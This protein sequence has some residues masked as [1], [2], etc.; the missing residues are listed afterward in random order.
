MILLSRSPLSC[1][2]A[3]H[4]TLQLICCRLEAA[5]AGT[6]S[7]CM[8]CS[9]FSPWEEKH[10]LPSAAAA[11]KVRSN[12]ERL[13]KGSPRI[14]ERIVDGGWTESMRSH[15]FPTCSHSEHVWSLD[16]QTQDLDKL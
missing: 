7:P 14:A 11:S 5:A 3:H 13:E 10:T 15:F 6:A 8:D 4:A 2:G 12:Y 16:I 1:L 9:L